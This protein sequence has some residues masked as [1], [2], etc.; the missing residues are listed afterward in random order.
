M[1]YNGDDGVRAHQ[2]A[3]AASGAV[4]GGCYCCRRVSFYIYGMFGEFN[5]VYGADFHTETTAFAEIVANLHGSL[6]FR[7]V[8]SPSS[9]VINDLLFCF[10][11]P[12]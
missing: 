7:H 4:A 2:S 8:D 6:N 10:I 3:V 11:I 9:L 1:P 12:K 5:N